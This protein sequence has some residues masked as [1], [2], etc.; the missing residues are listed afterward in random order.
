[1]PTAGDG[2]NDA[3]ALTRAGVGIAFGSGT[4]GA[5]ELAGTIVVKN[6]QLDGPNVV[7]LSWAK[8]RKMI[9]NPT[10]ATS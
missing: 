4:N 5:I 1:V 7:V 8:Y 6:N 2:V 10:W 3:P 9:Q